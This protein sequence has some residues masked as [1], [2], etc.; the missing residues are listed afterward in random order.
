MFDSLRRFYWVLLLLVSSPFF[1]IAPANSQMKLVTEIYPPFNYLDENGEITGISTEIL[2]ALMARSK[3]S[4][5]IS[6]LPWKR[7]YLKALS[8]KDTCVYSTAETPERRDLFKWVGP[9]VQN[10]WVLFARKGRFKR[11]LTLE[12]ARELTIGGYPGDAI[13]DFLI[14]EGLDVEVTGTDISNLKKLVLGR[15]DLWPSGLVIG[16]HLA[17]QEAIDIEPVTKLKTVRV[18]LACNKEIGDI[19]ISILQKNLKEMEEDGT[20]AEI[21]ASFAK[22][23]VEG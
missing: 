13:T 8:E 3:I 4:V 10:D 17:K 12:D 1:S 9:L 5:S 19:T 2:Q 21:E 22:S 18:S 20:I 15:I 16:N 6:V 23:A 14:S 7:A 11:Q